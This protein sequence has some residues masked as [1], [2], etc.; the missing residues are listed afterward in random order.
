MLLFLSLVWSSLCF[1]ENLWATAPTTGTRWPDVTAT[2]LT[3]AKDDEVEVLVKDADKVR[4]R[5][6][7]DFGWVAASALTNVAPPEPDAG[8]DLSSLG[9]PPLEG[10]PEAPAE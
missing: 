2:S 7:T 6:G 5:K 4:V 1:A 8:F 3:L 9:L 10:L